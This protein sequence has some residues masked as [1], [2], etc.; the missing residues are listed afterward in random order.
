MWGVL[1]SCT[2]V[3]LRQ[4]SPEK[5]RLLNKQDK[6]SMEAIIICQWQEVLHELQNS[7]LMIGSPSRVRPVSALAESDRLGIPVV[8]R[9]NFVGVV[10]NSTWKI[11]FRDIF[12]PFIPQALYTETVFR[13]WFD[14]GVLM[15]LIIDWRGWLVSWNVLDRHGSCSRFP[16]GYR[17]QCCGS[18][19]DQSFHIWQ[20][21]NTKQLLWSTQI[22]LYW[23]TNIKW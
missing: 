1:S 14:D 18:I 11:L 21:H 7:D 20:I 3:R 17:C 4:I 12:S 23:E 5:E 10:N 2:V 8:P 19:F 6:R 16:Q 13:Q 9:N 15:I 22:N